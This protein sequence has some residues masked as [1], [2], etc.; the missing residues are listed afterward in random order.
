M[1]AREFVRIIFNVYVVAKTFGVVDN[2][3]F[4]LINK[5]EWSNSVVLEL[6]DLYR[7]N[8]CLWNPIDNDYKNKIKK[9][10]AWNEISGILKCDPGEVKK[11]MESLLSSFRRERQKHEQSVKTGSGTNEIYTSTWFAFKNMLF[12]MDK[13][14]PKQTK[15]TEVSKH[16]YFITLYTNIVVILLY[17]Y[18]R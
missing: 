17:K 13:F 2:F 5:M 4:K 8:E 1:F 12:L 11:K 3:R 10:D 6:I 14:A 16:L 18:S 7:D 15:N 9:M